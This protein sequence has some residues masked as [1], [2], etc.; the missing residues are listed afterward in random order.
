MV[1]PTVADKLEARRNPASVVKSERA[2]HYMAERGQRDLYYLTTVIL[3]YDKLTKDT[4]GPL[5]DF[6]DT[7]NLTRRIFLYPRTHFKSTIITI[8]GTIQDVVKDA[9][10]TIL[11][12]AATAENAQRFLEEIKR[13]F[14]NNE[15]LRWLYPEMVWDSERAAPRWNKQEMEVPRTTFVRE[16]TIDTLGSRG[17]VISRHYMKIIPDDIIG[18]KE[19]KSV[20]EMQATC[21]WMGGL[22][23]LLV[24]PF[25]ERN[26]DFVGTRWT[27]DDAYAHAEYLYGGGRDASRKKLGPY[28]IKKGPRLGI[29]SREVRE[30]GVPIF[31]E[32]F[33]AGQLAEMQRT[34]PE[35]FAAQMMN[36]PLAGGVA[37]FETKWLKY[38]TY[39][40][41]EEKR[42]KLPDV[43]K[44][45]RIDRLPTF[46]LCDPS[47]GETKRSDRTAILVI[48][49]HLD[50]HPRLI[51][52]E[53]FIERIP[54]NQIIEKLFE[55]YR[56][57][58]WTR[59]VSLEVV[60]FQKAL[61]YWIEQK[62]VDER[63]VL[64]IHEFQ[65]GRAQGA[66]V[67]RI[68]G[69]QPICRAGQL[70]IS[71]GFGD[72]IDEYT[73]WHPQAKYDDGLDCL[74][75]ILEFID[76]GWTKES[77]SQIEEFDR[78][79][80]EARDPLTGSWSTY[81]PPPKRT[82]TIGV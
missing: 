15:V 13:H 82:R 45:I 52:L 74:S 53:A 58:I 43:E 78:L 62:Q 67:A 71:E 16:P 49:V 34:D 4:H 63:L 31:P 30:N 23:M 70:Y 20:G 39:V 59:A 3:G 47:L 22:E 12:V 56:K 81:D 50:E 17:E 46:I 9:N 61:K 29:F 51:M 69:L 44:P 14:M 73:A 68:K 65:G 54:P 72:F 35:R 42:I 5:C 8:A 75:Q 2:R 60:A 80:S 24:P 1:A 33:E 21:G 40:E 36:N 79:M 10:I 37:A 19:Y 27:M 25:W 6:H 57:Y 76:F 55:F 38:Y 48:S 7:C 28:A 41:G 77:W 64:P 18:E 66:K 32:M 11:L 26:I